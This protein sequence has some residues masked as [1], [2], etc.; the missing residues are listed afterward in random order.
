MN[1]AIP[2]EKKTKEHRVALI[3]EDVKILIEAGH[4]VFVEDYAGEKAG[5]SN[6]KYV[7]VGAEIVSKEEIYNQELIVKVKEPSLETIKENQIIMSYLH[8]EK[9]QNPELVA[10]LIEKNVTAYAYEMISVN[11]RRAISLGFEA[12]IVGMFEG[13]RTYG[14]TMKENPFENIQTIWAYNNKN[15][16][17]LELR[18]IDP[19]NFNAK[20]TIAG[21]GQ[22]S[23]GA[24][25][26]LAQ[27]SHPPIVLK[28]EDTVR[29]GTPK[30]WEHLS[31]TDIFFNAVLW[32][33]DQDRVI[34]KEDLK[35]MKKDSLIIDV[36]CDENGA[37]ETC[38]ATSWENP[39]YQVDGITHFCV[40]NLPSAL[41]HDSSKVLSK[42]ILSY[43]LKVA[44]GEV[45][46]TGLMTKDG[47]LS[48]HF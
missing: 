32:Y 26:V 35:R 14:K 23:K 18:K 2:K 45:L 19:R 24:Q 39:T 44:N 31:D 38:Q 30:I 8:I 12:G 16:A 4:K 36:S 33:P 7:K 5:F 20:I 10:K 3:P 47:K 17:Y 6:E 22:V 1:I 25:E 27:L 11:G 37:I 42:S 46:K 13:L 41:A 9:G 21:Y 15:E 40:D 34:T 43:V 29:K 48:E 28:E